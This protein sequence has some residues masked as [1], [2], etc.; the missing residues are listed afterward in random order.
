[1]DIAWEYETAAADI[2]GE[3]AR[4]AREDAAA[5]DET[6]VDFVRIFSSSTDEPKA[7]LSEEFTALVVMSSGERIT[8]PNVVLWSSVPVRRPSLFR[9]LFTMGA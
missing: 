5:V 1:M 8:V 7:E 3:H 4:Q 6:W 9:R 2:R